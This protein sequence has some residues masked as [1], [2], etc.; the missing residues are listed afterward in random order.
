MTSP[1][2][3]ILDG[4]RRLRRELSAMPIG[5][6]LRTLDQMREREL[7]IRK[8]DCSAERSHTNSR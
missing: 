3:K 1:L 4:K 5:E 7:T 2:D 8:S 6:K